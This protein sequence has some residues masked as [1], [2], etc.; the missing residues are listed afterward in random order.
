MTSRARRGMPI[1]PSRPASATATRCS[2]DMRW[3]NAALFASG[4]PVII[5]PAS[6]GT[7]AER[8]HRR[9]LGPERGSGAV[10]QRRA[11]LP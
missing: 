3:S 10:D 8:H 7:G 4:R 5:V 1:W 9:S 6:P 11:D 2:A